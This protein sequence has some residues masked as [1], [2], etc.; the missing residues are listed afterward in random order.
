MDILA[1]YICEETYTKKNGREFV[2]YSMSDVDKAVISKLFSIGHNVYMQEYDGSF[3][4]NFKNSYDVIFNL[5][6]GL[7][8]DNTFQEV[9]ILKDIEK[10]KVPFTGNTLKTVKRCIDKGRVKKI[11]IKEGIK[12]PR[13]QIFR[14]G[15]EKF[16]NL[17]FP[18][19]VKP[20]K[21]DAA[22]G[23][24]VDSYVKTE[25]RLY[26]KVNEVIK[27]NQQ[28][29]LVE[30]YIEGDEFSVPIMGNEK[31]VGLPPVRIRFCKSF[32]NKPRI[33]SY[34]AK[35]GGPWNL[36]KGIKPHI[37]K[38]LNLKLKKQL[39]STAWKS[40][41]AVGGSGYATVDTRVDKEGNIFVLEVN[42]NCYMGPRSDSAM[43]A[44]SIGMDYEQ[45]LEKI[46]KLGLKRKR[47]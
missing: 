33:L 36:E 27:T 12:T 37:P 11:L 34:T 40:F 47:N 17:E 46:I 45:F 38:N 4:K 26:K 3:L 1:L 16:K 32:R 28:P 42:P 39:L 19:I 21:T 31:S 30:E 5:C 7:E 44:R 14:E 18:L 6:D 41:K 43:A 24:K 25:K 8:N 10:T 20:L 2:E 23:L 35:W 15:N 22:C 29:A 13:F 9:K